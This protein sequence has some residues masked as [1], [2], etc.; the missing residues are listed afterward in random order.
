MESDK[1]LDTL[2]E[3]VKL[4]KGELKQTLAS[5]RDYLLNMELP[6]AEFSTI[7]AALGNGAEQRI[8]MRGS[9]SAPPEGGG[10]GEGAPG[11]VEE[12]S[13]EEAEEESLE[14][15]SELSSEEE[16]SLEPE[17]E[18]SSEEEESLEPESELSSE[19]EETY[20]PEGPFRA[21]SELPQGDELLSQDEGFEPEAELLSPE[22]ALEAGEEAF[23]EAGEEAFEEAGEE[24]LEEAGEEAFEEA[25]E[26]AGEYG[27]LDESPVPE[28][29]LS[30][31]EEQPMEYEKINAEV[32]RSTP[33]V[34]LLANLI[35]WVARAKKEIGHEQ[36]PVFLEVYGISGHLAP[37]LKEAILHLSEIASEQS[38]DA[39][40][41]EIWSQ[42]MLSLHGILTGGNAPLYPIKPSW[43]DAG[44]EIE[45]SEEEIIE[46]DKSKDK[47]VKLKL[48]FPNG[49]G[50]SKEFCVEL[51]PEANKDGS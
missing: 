43:N 8:T 2:E 10:P 6:T 32:S 9:F 47:P 33:K 50:E 18:L 5:V 44:S 29:E 17:S 23:E 19:K 15:E 46:V 41:A 3:E 16:E 11:P 12:P 37:E 21:K 4:M 22:D 20:G 38:E 30:V 26:E 40:T 49:E 13:P 34:N 42:S 31:E 36:I 48:V 24:A 28:S 51:T 25:G 7:L 39:R 35:N 14:P 45:P 27:E 1:T